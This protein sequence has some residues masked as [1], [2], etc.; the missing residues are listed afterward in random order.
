MRC[1]VIARLCLPALA[2]LAGPGTTAPSRADDRPEFTI[3]GRVQDVMEVFPPRLNVD[4]KTDRQSV[5]YVVQLVEDTKVL[6]DKKQVDFGQ[7][8]P[9][10]RVRIKGS[11][12]V[13][14]KNHHMDAREIKII[15]EGS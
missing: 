1:R 12:S 2:L 7:I 8:H 4:A 6:R 15:G 13:S 14:S 10:Q 5:R 9:R 3:E 11:T